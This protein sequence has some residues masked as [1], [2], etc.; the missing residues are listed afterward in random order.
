MP[1]IGTAG[2][3]GLLLFRLANLRLDSEDSTS[4]WSKEASRLRLRSSL[5]A[6][7]DIPAGV[8]IKLAARYPG[9]MCS[10]S[11]GLDPSASG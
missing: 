1:C 4:A 7:F 6:M 8:I 9:A 3:A 2:G 10:G 11:A 5:L